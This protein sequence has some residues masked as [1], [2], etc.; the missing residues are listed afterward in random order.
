MTIRRIPVHE[1]ITGELPTLPGAVDCRRAPDLFRPYL[2]GLLHAEAVQ[3]MEGHLHACPRCAA[4][5]EEHRNLHALLDGTLGARTL[6]A[7]FCERADQRLQERRRVL[8]ET[9]DTTA[10]GLTRLALGTA[11]LPEDAAAPARSAWARRLGAAPW[12]AVSGA[13]HGL[14]LLLLTL[15]GAALLRAKDDVVIVTE[16]A[17]LPPPAD[18]I[19]PVKRDLFKQPAPV[20]VQELVTEQVVE[21]HEEVEIAEHVETANDLDLQ[22][23][24]GDESAIAD[25][26]LGG[27]GLAAAIGTGGGG[28]GA[29]GH[30]LGGG[31]GRM[32]R[33][34]GGSAK[35][36]SAVD[37]GLAYL[38][39]VQE[40]DGHWD[41]KKH[42]GLLGKLTASHGDPRVVDTAITG[43]ALLAFLG[44]GH[45]EKVGKYKDNVTRAIDWLVSIQG[46]DGRLTSSG[47]AH[48]IAGMSLTEAAAMGRVERTKE[49]AQKAVKIDNGI[50][51]RKEWSSELYG[52]S[53]SLAQLDVLKG[54]L[55]NSGWHIM[56]LKS[57][58]TAGL[59]VEPAC[60][61]GAIRFMDAC[62]RGKVD[63]DP[64]S[65]HLYVYS[66]VDAPNHANAPYPRITAVG[67]LGRLFFGAKPEEL[68][69]GINF[70][71]E[72][73]GVPKRNDQGLLDL[74]YV[75]YASLVMFQAGGEEWKKWNT[76]LQA[77]LLPFQVKDGGPL[78]GSWK[79]WDNGYSG[80]WGRVGET[81]LSVLSLEVYYRY[82]PMYR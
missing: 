31:R 1:A 69:N 54:D 10:R 66:P 80:L 11:D 67:C 18:R 42:E 2:E 73:G 13:F 60:L 23:A 12:W 82:L 71:M 28:G 76:G 15:I 56:L 35:T 6:D 27:T 43:L 53:Y 50:G 34:G 62:E 37:A 9:P 72:K 65:G 38:A 79:P 70:I 68:Q 74:Y 5:L 45:T 61:E 48:A 51:L 25:V 29:Y 78:D 24:R 21:S 64:Y 7:A 39:R 4:A 77:S 14:L 26:P 52:W 57:A 40:A 36:E 58:K 46:Q 55:S 41:A 19:E 16:L 81:A 20:E 63:G 30:R 44:A 32:A 8:R 47:Y 22:S 33:R 75:Y 59:Q 49:A 3:R 17:K